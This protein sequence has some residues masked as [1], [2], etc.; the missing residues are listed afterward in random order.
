MDEAVPRCR[1]KVTGLAHPGGR[2]NSHL[3]G[4]GREPALDLSAARAGNRDYGAD[5]AQA[6]LIVVHRGCRPVRHR[7]GLLAGWTRGR[8]PR[9]RG[10][11]H[12]DC[13]RLAARLS[14]EI[15]SATLITAPSL[16]HA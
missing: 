7:D 14:P 1:P 9:H 12:A 15:V 3:C 2:G 8:V 16:S 11:A 6:F 13:T 4:H 5:G 10:S